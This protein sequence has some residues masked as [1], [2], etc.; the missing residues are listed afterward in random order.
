MKHWGDVEE[1]KQMKANRLKKTKKTEYRKEIFE[2]AQGLGT[3]GN[4]KS[5]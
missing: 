5:F 2:A 1:K 3:K 4:G